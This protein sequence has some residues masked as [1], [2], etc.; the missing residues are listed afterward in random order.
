VRN[1]LPRSSNVFERYNIDTDK[2]LG[3]ALDA[4]LQLRHHSPRRAPPS[5][6]C[7]AQCPSS[8]RDGAHAYPS[9]LLCSDEK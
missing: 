5:T 9:Q 3:D 6:H 1:S 2:E 4:V 8:V 7:A